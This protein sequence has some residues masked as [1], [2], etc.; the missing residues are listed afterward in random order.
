DAPNKRV[1][2]FANIGELGRIHRGTPWQTL[3]LKSIYTLQNTP[4]GVTAVPLPGTHP[5]EWKKWA[6]SVGTHPMHD[7]KLLDVFTTAAHENA[8]R[9]LLSVNQTNRAAWSAVL[10]G[11]IVATNT[12]R[13]N[14]ARLLGDHAGADPVTAY[15]ATY[16]EPATPQIATIVDS[17]HY[18]RHKQLDIIP[19]PNLAGNPG[20]PWDF[21]VKRNP[22]TGRTNTVFARLGDILSAPHLTVQ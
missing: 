11:V 2:F 21:T 1:H 7:W 17:I 20:M 16:I 9:G 13:N 14:E 10:S 19:N 6:G 15:K 8:T 18:A 5:T 22:I 4:N 12:V 3:Y